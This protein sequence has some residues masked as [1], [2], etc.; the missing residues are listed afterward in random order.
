M[1]IWVTGCGGFLGQR[2]VARLGAAGHCLVG[3]SRTPVLVQGKTVVVDLASPTARQALLEAVSSFGGPDV[4]IHAAARQPGPHRTADYVN[5]NVLTTANLLDALSGCPPRQL[6]YTSTLSVYGVP[7]EHPVREESPTSGQSPYA[8]TKLAAEDLCALFQG[9]T[10]IFRLPTLYGAGH[11]DSF[12]DG[13]AR[14]AIR[15]ELIELYENGGRVREALHVEDVVD[16]ILGCLDRSP[17]ERASF[18]NLGAGRPITS[19]EY[20]AALVAALKSPSR[21]LRVDEHSAQ[22][23]DL[24]VDIAKA[25]R[26]IGF[27]PSPLSQ[28][29]KRYADE[30]QR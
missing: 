25:R 23:F 8:V 13:L 28:S 3:F 24:H 16:A 30:L 2:L 12:V 5:G 9:T 29:M 4:V 1:K 27:S 26:E 22:A 20:A 11:R 21:L 17:T 6:I 14:L 19:W 10:V 7:S 18:F 15:G